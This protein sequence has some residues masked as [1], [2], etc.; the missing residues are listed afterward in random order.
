MN[1]AQNLANI[2]LN[3]YIK[4]EN[5]SYLSPLKGQYNNLIKHSFILYF[6]ISS[7]DL[8]KLINSIISVDSL[9]IVILTDEKMH[10]INSCNLYKDDYINNRFLNCFDF[11]SI[12]VL[13]H[14]L[15][16]QKI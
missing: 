15:L 12:L 6:K 5:I 4:R 9:L 13:G 10:N 1:N 14:H 3:L 7:K 11:F 16:K 2:Y 8:F